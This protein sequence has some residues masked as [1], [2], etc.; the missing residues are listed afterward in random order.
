MTGKQV[1]MFLP[2]PHLAQ[3]VSDLLVALSP[4]GPRHTLVSEDWTEWEAPV[5]VA[6]PR[7]FMASNPPH[8][9]DLSHIFLDEPDVMLGPLPGRYSSD[10]MY[11]KHRIN[12]HP[13][14]IAQAL[15]S[16]LQIVDDRGKLDFSNR[17]QDV[18]TVWASA[19]FGPALRRFTYLRG[20]VSSRGEK[21][22]VADLNLTADASERQASIVDALGEIAQ[23]VDVKASDPVQA[24]KPLHYAF[25]VDETARLGPLPPVA[26]NTAPDAND[27]MLDL[28]VIEAM[29]YLHTTSPPP[30]G[31]YALALPPSS[32]SLKALVQE[33][34][35]LGVPV[36]PLVPEAL[37]GG[38]PK[39]D[40]DG[41]AP[42]LVSSRAA[43]A[44]LHLPELH[45]V[46]M[47]NGLDMAGTTA[48]QRS[49]AGRTGGKQDRETQYE[50]IAGRLGRMG[51][52]A[53]NIPSRPQRVISLLSAGS[54][55]IAAMRDLLDGNLNAA[56]RVQFRLSEWEGEL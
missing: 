56:H 35:L 23:Q 46:Y 41:I 19:T 17:R 29:A 26:F 4:G 28:T 20:W 48:S 15:N 24:P 36:A 1:I 11:K 32:A 10:G 13:P 33:L 44:G 53:A 18:N 12:L 9:P 43:M 54:S 27:A 50:V 37:A 31:T 14:P 3:Q 2:T 34:G 55:E 30:P 21:S 16:I 51:T 8:L 39:P 47:L 25:V 45:T 22:A 42:V 38:I 52:A 7:T 40:R 5:I 49:K 6:T